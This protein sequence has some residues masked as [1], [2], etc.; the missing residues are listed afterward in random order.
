MPGPRGDE[1]LKNDVGR[2]FVR[3]TD[4][5]GVILYSA[6]HPQGMPVDPIAEPEAIDRPRFN[7]DMSNS[8]TLYLS[9]RTGHPISV[10]IEDLD[11]HTARW[12]QDAARIAGESLVGNPD[13]AADIH[14]L[15]VR[16]GSVPELD[17][18][19]EGTLIVYVNP[20]DRF[21]GRPSS[22]RVTIFLKNRMAS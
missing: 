2:L 20:D 22:D 8:L 4:L 19:D 14:R 6:S 1:F 9:L 5:G 10:S 13:E 15:E 11:H 18:S 7:A 17:L 3:L 16:T 21:E 12:L